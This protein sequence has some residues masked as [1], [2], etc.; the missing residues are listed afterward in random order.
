MKSGAALNR[1]NSKQ[2]YE[3]PD[4]FIEAVERRFGR[5]EFDLAAHAKNTKHRRFFS[6]Q[7]NSLEQDWHQ[8]G[9]LLWLNPEFKYIAPWAEKCKVEAAKGARIAL[10][11]PAS[12]GT[13]WF[14][15]HVH[16]N[17]LVLGLSPRL[18][19]GGEKTPY[20]KDL[21]L[22]MFGPAGEVPWGRGFDVWRWKL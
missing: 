19:F 5:I 21:M 22:S 3:T 2:D 17:A 9:G 15:E 12:V 18:T 4:E 8:L 10:L 6:K 14:A 11:T 20:P 16:G 1:H 13:V 7:H